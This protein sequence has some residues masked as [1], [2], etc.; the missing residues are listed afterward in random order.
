MSKQYLDKAGLTYLWGKIKSNFL[1]GNSGGVFYGTCSTAAGTVAKV[2]ECAD[3]TA[4]NLKAGAII[5]VT[6]T[7]TNS[8]AVANLTMNVNGTGA[9]H[10]KYI[11]NGTLGN[12]SSAGYLKANTE[13]PFYYD[14]ANWVCW[15]NVNTTYSALSEADMH[16]GT[17]TTARLI[18]AQ[19]LKQ[20]VEYH[21]PV[22]SVNGNTG[23]VTVTVP[24]KTSE[25]T[26]DSGFLTS[27]PVTSVNHQTGAVI[28][29]VPT[30]TSDL[31]NN[32]DDGTSAFATYNYLTTKGYIRAGDLNNPTFCA[33]DATTQA[34]LQQAFGA[35]ADVVVPSDITS[36]PLLLQ[37]LEPRTWFCW[38]NGTEMEFA[39]LSVSVNTSNS[40]ITLYL[41]GR[42]SIATGIMGVD[43]SWTVTQIQNPTATQDS[44]TKV[45][46]LQS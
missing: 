40:A 45:L 13:Y 7:A 25:L 43:S 28:I 32:G 26:N 22:T 36:T 41:R 33:T 17:A 10:I 6:F 39:R 30:K 34:V 42:A 2:V 9:K 16:T 19:R 37:K 29:S 4:D 24:T 5:I 15:F 3:F 21:A 20:A 23:D 12:L 11:N 18:T 46:T 31:T 38:M 35:S 8:G 44:I 14:G 1:M 27:A